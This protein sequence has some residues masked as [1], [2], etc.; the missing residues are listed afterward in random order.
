MGERRSA[1]RWFPGTLLALWVGLA[2]FPG[3]ADHGDPSTRPEPDPKP[4]VPEAPRAVQRVQQDQL[5]LTLTMTPPTPA[6]GELVRFGLNILD[7]EQERDFQGSVKVT[8]L[9]EAGNTLA[10]GP[11]LTDDGE[12]SF[13][14]LPGAGGR[15]TVRFEFDADIPAW[16]QAR[17]QRPGPST[18]PLEAK[19]D[20]PGSVSVTFA[21]EGGGAEMPIP[22]PYIVGGGV[23]LLLA[24]I[25]F[26]RKKS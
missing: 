25:V 1:P 4:F 22:L 6:V 24:A 5:V 10:A 26:L 3:V 9:D 21:V 2:A 23:L 14:Y 20:K 16:T 8:V 7:P 12:A 15:Q 11:A 19:L 18:P 17:I 13:L